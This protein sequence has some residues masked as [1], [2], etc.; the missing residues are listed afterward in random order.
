MKFAQHCNG[1]VGPGLKIFSR[2]HAIREPALSAGRGG[3][4]FGGSFGILRE[5]FGQFLGDR[6]FIRVRVGHE[7]DFDTLAGNQSQRSELG[8]TDHEARSN[9]AVRPQ[10]AGKTGSADFNLQPGAGA[11][12]IRRDV[13]RH[14]DEMLLDAELGADHDFAGEA[15][16]RVRGH[17]VQ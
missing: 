1:A 13:L 4:P 8:L 17:R 15:A 14:R 3:V 16:G 9:G 11:G 6:H 12:E 5:S 2:I 10:G 7:G